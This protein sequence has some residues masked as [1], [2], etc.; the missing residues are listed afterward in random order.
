MSEI[1]KTARKV[2]TK[3]KND[4]E[5]GSRHDIIEELF[6]DLHRSRVEVYKMNFVR[7]IFF[8]F[9]SVLGGTV[10]I[11]ILAWILSLFVDLPGIG[12]SIEQFQESIQM[13]QK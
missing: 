1:K 10:I 4:N 9:G 2:S 12:R 3:I 8:G 13:Q 7:G 11:A 5:R 6:Y